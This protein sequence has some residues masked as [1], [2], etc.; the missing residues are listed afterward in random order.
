MN[1][2]EEVYCNE[3]RTVADKIVGKHKHLSEDLMSHVLIKFT[4]LKEEKIESLMQQKK[5]KSYFIRVMYNEFNHPQNTFFKQYRSRQM[6]IVFEQHDYA[7][8][9]KIEEVL[10]AIDELPSHEYMTLMS[11]INYKS[12]NEMSRATTIN[13]QWITTTINSV[14]N[15][16]K[17]V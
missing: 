1:W 3:V 17:C 13:R 14:K 12:I 15:K 9:R 8:D 2:M 6:H 5:L 7:K 10:K 11:V 4:L 16:L